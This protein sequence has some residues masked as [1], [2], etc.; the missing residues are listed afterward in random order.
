MKNLQKLSLL[1]LFCLFG[2]GTAQAQFSTVKLGAKVGLNVSQLAVSN[3][4]DTRFEGFDRDNHF[5]IGTFGD[6][7]LRS[8]F[9]LKVEVLYSRKGGQDF[10]EA[11]SLI[12]RDD[13]QK[14]RFDFI[15]LPVL[16]TYNYKNFQLEAGIEGAF[17]QSTRYNI[18][19]ISITG[20]ERDN[21]YDIGLNLGVAYHIDRLSFGVRY[22]HGF[23]PMP[24]GS[25]FQ[26]TD[27]NTY[28]VQ[29]KFLLRTWQFTVGYD[30][31]NG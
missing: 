1:L 23:N 31:V 13:Q 3:L 18:A 14:V 7:R 4:A 11:N 20:N 25:F 24:V 27:G 9:G 19:L 15:T 17:R 6:F 28:D 16:L 12:S 26:D 30:L 21:R 29:P 5:Q 22:N 8:G 10:A 2:F